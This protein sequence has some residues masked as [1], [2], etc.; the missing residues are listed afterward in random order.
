MNRII[1]TTVTEKYGNTEKVF[2]SNSVARVRTVNVATEIYFHFPSILCSASKMAAS[3]ISPLRK[4]KS[5]TYR[6]SNFGNNA[7]DSQFSHF[8][9]NN[10]IG[11][12]RQ[13]HLDDGVHM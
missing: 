11:V 10:R 13:S 7:K 1:S 12:Y 2:R 3:H 4:S 6:S 8:C 9:D 5:N